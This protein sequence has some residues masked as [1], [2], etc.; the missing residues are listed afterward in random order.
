MPKL[1]EVAREAALCVWEDKKTEVAAA[2][3]TV[4]YHS[5]LYLDQVAPALRD[6]LLGARKGAP[7]GPLPWGEEFAL[8]LIRDKILPSLDDSGIWRQQRATSC[9]AHRQTEVRARAALFAGIQA[10]R[11]VCS[12]DTVEGPGR[13]LAV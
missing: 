9:A 6:R 10:E 11:L 7:V 13:P 2:V 4:V 12:S 3:K 8:F 5:R 1:T